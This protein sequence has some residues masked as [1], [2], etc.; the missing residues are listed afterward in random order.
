MMAFQYAPILIMH[1]V[2]HTFG[3]C[4]RFGDV[5]LQN[6]ESCPVPAGWTGC[7]NCANCANDPNYCGVDQSS[8]TAMGS[9]TLLHM[10]GEALTDPGVLTGIG[11]GIVIGALIG[12]LAGPVGAV[13]GG[14][15]GGLLGGLLGGLFGPD[16]GFSEYDPFIRFV[17]YDPKEWP[18]LLF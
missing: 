15:I 12:S 18:A 16:F 6:C 17:D 11:G 1:E 2:G 8:I 4:H 9:D 10:I 3:L 5:G 14:I 7:P 13:V